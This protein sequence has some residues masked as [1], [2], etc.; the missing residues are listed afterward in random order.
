MDLVTNGVII[1]DAI[2]FVQ[3][4]KEDL[5]QMDSNKHISGEWKEVLDSDNDKYEEQNLLTY[6]D[7]SINY[8][9]VISRYEFNKISSRIPKINGSGLNIVSP[10]YFFFNLDII[11]C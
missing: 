2:K 1:T 11:L 10:C 8:V 9:P 3:E 4:K 6:F 7:K 5:N